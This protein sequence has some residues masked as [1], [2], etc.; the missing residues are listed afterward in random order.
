M[1]RALLALCLLALTMPLAAP[2]ALPVGVRGPPPGDEVALPTMAQPCLS[3]LPGSTLGG[4]VVASYG[5][6]DGPQGWATIDSAN[7]P[8][9]WHWTQFK[10]NG[11]ANDAMFHGGPGRLYYGIE[12]IFG[13]TYNTSRRPNQGEFRSPSFVVPDGL[14]AIV[15]HAKWHVEWDRAW[16]I[17]SMQVGY[18]NA[19]GARTPLCT[20]GNQYAWVTNLAMGYG[21]YQTSP[22]GQAILTGCEYSLESPQNPCRAAKDFLHQD[23]GFDLAPDIALWETRYV[24]IPPTLAGQTLKVSV[25]FQTGDAIVDDAMGWMIDDVQVVK[26]A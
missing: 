9:L 23:I 7:R 18:A 5:F 10:G 15:L 26:L 17:D 21:Y 3:A 6:E 8:N 14:A 4:T 25:Y 24:L 1:R 11:S 12:N 22:F 13:G 16:L 2:A 19:A 20:L